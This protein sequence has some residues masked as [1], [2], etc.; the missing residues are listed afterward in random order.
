MTP[1]EAINYLNL[2]MSQPEIVYRLA[3]AGTDTTQATISRI[4][5]GR[6]AQT[7]YELGA[8]IVAIA[9]N[10]QKESNKV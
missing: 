5:S 10:A 1:K 2:Q 6:S 9:A 4:G 7:S 3:L 8:A